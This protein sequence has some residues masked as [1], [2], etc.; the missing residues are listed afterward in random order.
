MGIP[1]LSFFTGGGFLDIGFEKA[2]F[3]IA[4]TNESN[5]EFADMYEYALTALRK[6]KGVSHVVAKVSNRNS[7]ED[8]TA[9]GVLKE[10]FGKTRP[11]IF[12]LIGGP[13]CPDFSAGGKNG[14]FEDKHGRLTKTFFDLICSIKPHFFLMENVPG[15]IRTKKHQAFLEELVRRAEKH[16]YIID[17][18][19]L[20]ALELGVP[21]DRQRVFVIGFRRNLFTRSLNRNIPAGTRWPEAGYEDAKNLPWPKTNEFGKEVSCPEGIP[22]NLTVYPLLSSNPEPEDLPNGKEF[23]KPHSAKF[24]QRA[25]GDVSTQSFKRLH[26]YRYSPTA[27]YGN[28]EV[29][30]HP[31][32]PRR[33]SVR[34]TLRIQTVPDE[35]VLPPEKSLTAKFKMI[36]NGVPCRM[37]KCVAQSMQS[38][39]RSNV[40]ILEPRHNFFVN[41]Y[42]MHRREFPWR[43]EDVSPFHI[44]ITE[45]LLRQTK[46]SMVSGMWVE[47][48]TKYPDPEAIVSSNEN[49]LVDNLRALG[50]V[51]QRS[52]A[53]KLASKWLLDNHDGKV[54]D[55]EEEL[56]KIPH[57]GLYTSRAVLCFAFGYK[58]P[59]VDQNILR[60]FSRYYGLSVK[61]DIRR[62]STVL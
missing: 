59:I 18:K 1:L 34:E 5:S 23:F 24:W 51:N 11:P 13:P 49:S 48:T 35:Y 50:F 15:L 62:D 32:K 56:F 25:E 33:L 47:F 42:N 26:R 43:Q 30:L 27:W 29:H 2:G 16:G 14:G 38:F 19:V 28:N 45:M 55:C 4:W 54:P 22:L 9:R 31:W 39:L 41:W 44:L 57:V 53:L 3:D 36:C 8:L 20:N 58:I 7:I 46:A 40:K 37:A 10:A 12:G 6:A 60:F 17:Q 21:Q 61:P 52:E